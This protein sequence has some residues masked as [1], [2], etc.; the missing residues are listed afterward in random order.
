MHVT[1]R[2]FDGVK[3]DRPGHEVMFESDRFPGVL[4]LRFHLLPRGRQGPGTGQR[5][6]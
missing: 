2:W 4:I 5:R 3:D 1:Y 6:G